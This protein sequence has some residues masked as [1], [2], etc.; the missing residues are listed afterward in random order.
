[1][2]GDIVTLTPVESF[3]IRIKATACLGLLGCRFNFRARNPKHRLSFPKSTRS[4][5]PVEGNQHMGRR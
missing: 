4:F 1:M 2:I 5:F 3:E